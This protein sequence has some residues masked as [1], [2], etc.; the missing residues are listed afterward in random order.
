MANMRCKCYILTRKP[1]CSKGDAR[2][3]CVYKDPDKQ[4]SAHWCYKSTSCWWLIVSVAPYFTYRLRH[5]FCVM[6]L[7]IAISE[8]IVTRKR[9]FIRSRSS[10][11]YQ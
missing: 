10:N 11:T 9:P 6:R 8:D 5:I 3:H 4:F 2:Q 7:K 1:S